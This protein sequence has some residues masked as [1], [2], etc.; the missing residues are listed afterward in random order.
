MSPTANEARAIASIKEK[1]R[2]LRAFLEAE[3]LAESADHVNR[4]LREEGL[5]GLLVPSWWS[6]VGT[7]RRMEFSLLL[8]R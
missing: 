8:P 2:K 6:R 4:T 3:V 1:D 5:A 7:A